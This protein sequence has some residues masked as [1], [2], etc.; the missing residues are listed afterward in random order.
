MKRI[1]EGVRATGEACASVGMDATDGADSF[2]NKPGVWHCITR[3]GKFCNVM[4]IH[5]S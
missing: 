4:G 1:S 3:L 5:N 2:L